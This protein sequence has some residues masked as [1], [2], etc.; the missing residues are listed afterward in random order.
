MGEKTNQDGLVPDFDIVLW[1]YDRQQVRQ[2]LDDMTARLEEA[3]SQRDAVELLQAELCEAR[4]EIEQLRLAAEENPT[5]ADRL[6]KIMMTAEELRTRAARDAEAIRAGTAEDRP[7]APD[8]HPMLAK[9]AP[10]AADD[11]RVATGLQPVSAG[12]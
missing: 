7:V 2:C 1:G 11:R 9:D 6:S 4:L 12:D 10:V 5:A 3:L 8:V